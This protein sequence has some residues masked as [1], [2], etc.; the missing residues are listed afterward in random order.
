MG[1]DGELMLAA[2]GI[3]APLRPGPLRVTEQ[4]RNRAARVQR[5]ISDL[6]AT[7]LDGHAF[8]KRTKSDGPPPPSYDDVLTWLS[9]P[10]PSEQRSSENIAGIIDDAARDEYAAALG[11]AWGYLQREIPAR[12]RKAFSGRINEPPTDLDLARFWRRYQVVEDPTVVFTDMTTAALVD[13][14]VD[15]LATIYPELY[16]WAQGELVRQVVEKKIKTPKWELLRPKERI[17]YLLMQTSGPDGRL[18]VAIQQ[19]YEAQRQASPA[20]SPNRGG[21]G[22][23]VEDAPLTPTQRLETK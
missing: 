20:N 18:Q 3:T 16:A 1:L 2:S 13:D 12:S 11:R 7:F 6:I 4:A 23:G 21:S 14:Q 10:T 8:E 17:A 19:A 9:E 5:R 15:A 22:S